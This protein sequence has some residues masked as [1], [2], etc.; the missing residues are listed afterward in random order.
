MRFSFP[1]TARQKIL[2][3]S[4]ARILHIGAGTKTGKARVYFAG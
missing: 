1:F 3:E 4:T 2:M